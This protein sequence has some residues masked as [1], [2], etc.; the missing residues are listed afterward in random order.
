MS[1]YNLAINSIKN[2][3]RLQRLLLECNSDYFKKKRAMLKWKKW[4]LN[5]LNKE[6]MLVLDLV[7]KKSNG[8]CGVILP[9][10]ECKMGGKC[11]PTRM[12]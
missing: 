1:W 2:K 8:A 12:M 7:I 11:A 10:K 9:A 4:V 3:W 6:A 5:S